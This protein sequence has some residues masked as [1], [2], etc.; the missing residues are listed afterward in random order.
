MTTT[1]CEDFYRQAS[2]W[3]IMASPFTRL[4]IYTE[5]KNGEDLM[6]DL[7]RISLVKFG[8]LWIL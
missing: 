8:V 3:E 7:I 6:F 2:W 5:G 4:Y 1:I